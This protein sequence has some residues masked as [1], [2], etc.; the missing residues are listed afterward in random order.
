MALTATIYN[1]SIELADMDRGVYE[2]LDIKAAQHPSET[3]EALLARVLAYCCE[4][5][6]GI[7]FSKGISTPDDPAVFIRDLTGTL[8]TWIDIGAPDAARIHRASK[9]ADRVVVYTHKD[10]RQMLANWSG[11]RIHKAASIDVFSFDAA[12]LAALVRKLDR[13]MAFSLS[14]TDKH[15]YVAFADETIDGVL[16]R[17]SLS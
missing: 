15:L 6:E 13:R 16:T 14:I 2:T 5:G 11:E 12:F 10:P 17:Q 3:D 9:A 8:R 1:F 4:Y 7:G